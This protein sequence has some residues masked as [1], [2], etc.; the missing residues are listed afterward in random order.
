M[1]TESSGRVVIEAGREAG[2]EV[3]KGLGKVILG[4]KDI[5]EVG[6]QANTH[7]EHI[8]KGISYQSGCPVCDA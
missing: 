4:A 5:I 8:E 6:S 7:E 1:M 3:G 2:K